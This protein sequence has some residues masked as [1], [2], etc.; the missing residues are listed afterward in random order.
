[1][2]TQEHRDGGLFD[3]TSDYDDDDE[4]EEFEEFAPGKKFTKQDSTVVG[5]AETAL[6]SLMD[7]DESRWPPEPPLVYLL[8]SL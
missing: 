3:E 4:E 6:D 8:P 2:D 1:M 5:S 7:K